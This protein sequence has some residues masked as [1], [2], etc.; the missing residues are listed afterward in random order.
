MRT[1][2][3]GALSIFGAFVVT[4]GPAQAAVSIVGGGLAHGCSQAAVDGKD[5]SDSLA[6][7]DRA[8]YEEMMLRDERAGTLVNRGVILLR[9]QNFDNARKDFDAA[10]K[11]SPNLGE[12]FVNRGAAL[13]AERQYRAGIEQ[14]DL[15]LALNPEDPAKAYF[16]RALAHEHLDDLLHAYQDFNKA[17]EL[18]PEWSAPKLELARYSVSNR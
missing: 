16:N 15:G 12:A 6:L 3:L 17:S 1:T 14:I 18:A 13:I 11:L 9:R 8:L 4:I 5:D 7:C 10:I 2:I